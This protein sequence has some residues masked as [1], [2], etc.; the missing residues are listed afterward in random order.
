MRT[1]LSVA[2]YDPSSGAGVT[3]DLETVVACGLHGLTAP[4]CSVIQGPLGV[5][6]I[7][8]ADH[9]SFR[10]S[11]K[12]LS[13]ETPIDG[14]KVGVLCD[15]YYV[16][17]LSEFLG[18]WKVPI[19]VDPVLTAKNGTRLITDNGL[20]SLIDRI[21]PLTTVLTPNWD[22]AATLSGQTV[23]DLDS[24]E[25]A[26]RQLMAF[27]P[28]AVLVKGGH[29]DGD[30]IDLLYD[31]GEA[32]LWSRRRLKREIHG[33]GCTLSSLLVS[34]LVLGYGLKE[35]FAAA[36]QRMEKTMAGSYTL[37]RHG[38]SYLSP[39]RV[40]ADQ[41]S[42]FQVMESLK[43]ARD[44]LKVLNPVHLVPEVQ[45]NM[46]FAVEGARGVDDVAAF[47]GRIGAHR[48]RLIFKEP[49]EFGASSHVARL[50]LNCMKFFPHVRSAANLRFEEAFIDRA[51]AAGMEVLYFDRKGEPEA[52][53]SAE[54]RSLDFLMTEALKSRGA[55]PDVIYD[56]GDVG[57]EPIMRLFARTPLELISRMEM[58]EP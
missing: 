13:E 23:T 49:P 5:R 25:A 58:I 56:R 34:F 11:L 22:E 3:K 8:P 40:G 53:K 33:T 9:E 46:G 41:A 29:G 21:L 57:K 4:T 27:G 26:A 37:F 19:V 39:G 51:R 35:A 45:M 24:A 44:R 12:V 14:V 48:G 38:Y 28:K 1:V 32:T 15:T 7:F 18:Q 52:L 31:G 55:A 43:E 2:G 42:R 47:P 16:E 54:G 20:K 36:E 30:P 50:I 10:E 17:T 6:A